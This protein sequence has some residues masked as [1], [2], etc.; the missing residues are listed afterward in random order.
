MLQLLLE[1]R[2]FKL[3]STISLVVLFERAF[4]YKG[5]QTRPC[6]RAWREM[7]PRV[8]NDVVSR[9]AGG[10]ATVGDRW[11]HDEPSTGERE[12]ALGEGVPTEC[13]RS[14]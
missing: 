2:V 5:A 3:Q 14:R 4:L 13:G 8:A 1:P 7:P 10:G 6:C 11:W 12:S 9:N